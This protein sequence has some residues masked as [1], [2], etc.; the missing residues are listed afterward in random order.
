MVGCTK[1]KKLKKSV[2]EWIGFELMAIKLPTLYDFD[3]RWSTIRLHGDKLLVKC[4]CFQD[5]TSICSICG[6]DIYKIFPKF[7][8]AEELDRQNIKVWKTDYRCVFIILKIQLRKFQMFSL[9]VS[10]RFSTNIFIDLEKWKRFAHVN[11]F[12]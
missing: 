2:E 1:I 10:Y 7:G 11:I 4:I 3:I 6:T 8:L 9:I 12:D 5:Q